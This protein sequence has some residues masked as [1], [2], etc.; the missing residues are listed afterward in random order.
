MLSRDWFQ[1]IATSNTEDLFKKHCMR[2]RG[3]LSEQRALCIQYHNS[4]VIDA[5]IL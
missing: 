3:Y 2:V 1:T 5:N 4:A